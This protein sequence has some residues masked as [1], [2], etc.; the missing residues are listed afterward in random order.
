MVWDEQHQIEGI[1][2]NQEE[3]CGSSSG[4]FSATKSLLGNFSRL[5]AL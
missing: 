3:L 1:H 4:A 5:F 2:D